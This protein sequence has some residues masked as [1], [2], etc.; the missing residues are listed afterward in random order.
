MLKIS[1]LAQAWNIR[2]APHAME[3]I[4]VHLIAALSNTLFLEQLVLFEPLW[5]AVFKNLP[6]VENGMMHVPQAPGLG[7]MLDEDNIREMRDRA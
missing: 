1:A 6:K 2:F 5:N 3:Y 4:N 7:L